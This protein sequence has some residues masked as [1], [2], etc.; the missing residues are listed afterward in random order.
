MRKP[1][2]K[3]CFIIHY[4]EKQSTAPRDAEV[5]RWIYHN[6]MRGTKFYVDEIDEHGVIQNSYIYKFSIEGPIFRKQ[7]YS[8]WKQEIQTARTKQKELFFDWAEP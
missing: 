6:G 2:I 4:M 8:K 3:T 7:T 5:R 1:K